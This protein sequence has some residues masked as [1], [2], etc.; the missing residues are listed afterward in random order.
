MTQ[1]VA[2]P[3]PIRADLEQEAL[4]LLDE[5]DRRGV[6]ARLIGGMA[7]RLLAG[8]R[9]H[10]A[11]VREVK[12]HDFVVRRGASRELEA[13]L[14]DAGYVA[15]REFNALNGARRMLFHDPAHGRQVDV[16]VETFEMCHALP[17]AERLEARPMTLPAAEV[18][19]TKLQIVQ[20]TAKDRSDLYALLHT[21]EPADGEGEHRL[22]RSRIVELTGNDW[23]LQRTFELSLDQLEAGLGDL[24]VDEGDRAAIGDRVRALRTAMDEAPKTRRWRLRARIGERKRWYEEP[25]EVQRGA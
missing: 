19:M 12:D 4:R 3:T 7:I 21:H 16:F 20:L 23:G 5:I 10:R 22:D 15:D 13:V 8:E 1:A 6:A 25:E 11:F 17:L 18:L 9:L 24:A 2:E 14:L